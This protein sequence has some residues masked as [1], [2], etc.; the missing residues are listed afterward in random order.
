MRRK[1]VGRAPRLSLLVRCRFAKPGGS[2]NASPD[3][4]CI[5]RCSSVRLRADAG[6]PSFRAGRHGPARRP[7]LCMG[8]ERWAPH[9][10]Q[11]GSVPARPGRSGRLHRQRNQRRHAQLAGF[12]ELHG[13]ARLFTPLDLIVSL[14]TGPAANG[15]ALV[16]FCTMLHKQ[17]R[18][19]V[20]QAGAQAGPFCA[21]AAGMFR[22]ALTPPMMVLN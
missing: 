2:S 21:R 15:R 12:H 19:S 18:F 3:C 17:D 8:A 22:P 4:S 1:H 5:R 13:S 9:G 16:R 20:W 6:T 11:S 10:R 14:R 7:E